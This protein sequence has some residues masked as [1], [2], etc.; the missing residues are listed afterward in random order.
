MAGEQSEQLVV[1]M[2]TDQ[3]GNVSRFEFTQLLLDA[4]A[5]SGAYE[6]D[7]YMHEMQSRI[8]CARVPPQIANSG[9]SRRLGDIVTLCMVQQQ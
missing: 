3:D 1:Q 7:E 9:A 5:D 8:N 2:D 4:G 6:F